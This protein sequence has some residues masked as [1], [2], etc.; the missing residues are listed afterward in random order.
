MDGKA[1]F[2]ESVKT[3]PVSNGVNEVTAKDE[4]E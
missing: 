3:L 2:K 4:T 1:V